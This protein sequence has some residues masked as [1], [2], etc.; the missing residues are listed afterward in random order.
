MPRK[1]NHPDPGSPYLASWANIIVDLTQDGPD[2]PL[3]I[4]PNFIAGQ[5][6]L[7]VV[8][9][10]SVAT[11]AAEWTV[12]MYD[13]AL[14]NQVVWTQTKLAVAATLQRRQGEVG[15]TGDYFLEPVVFDLRGIAHVTRSSRY[16]WAI[17]MSVDPGGDNRIVHLD[18]FKRRPS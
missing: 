4:A 13:G 15:A 18:V 16:R 8:T 17:Y 7:R 2:S 5:D 14:D 9:S 1:S 12:V 3:A 10:N 11:N 6:F